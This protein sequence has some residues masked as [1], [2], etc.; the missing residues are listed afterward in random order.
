MAGCL[1]SVPWVRLIGFLAV[2]RRRPVAAATGYKC[3]VPLGSRPLLAPAGFDSGGGGAWAAKN[4]AKFIFCEVFLGLGRRRLGQ[5]AMY[6]TILQRNM[7]Y[8]KVLRDFC[9]VKKF[10]TV[11]N[12]GVLQKVING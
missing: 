4:L 10:S 11:E 7:M 6:Y 12:F 1:A 3:G 5:A 2:R 8:Y 9:V